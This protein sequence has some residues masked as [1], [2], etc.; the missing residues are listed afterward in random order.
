MDKI[1]IDVDPRE[2][3]LAGSIVDLASNQE[4]VLHFLNAFGE[5]PDRDGLKR[6]PDRVA[7]MFT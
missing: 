6:T 7:R 3:G 4:A 1:D 5:N 2:E